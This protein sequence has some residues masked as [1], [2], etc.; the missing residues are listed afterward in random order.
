[1]ITIPRDKLDEP[2]L[3]PE[4][5]ALVRILAAREGEDE[6]VVRYQILAATDAAA[7]GVTTTEKFALAP[8]QI[9]KLSIL[10]KRAG[11]QERGTPAEDAAEFDPEELV[12]LELVV[13][14]VHHKFQGKKG[15]DITVSQ[16]PWGAYWPLGDPKVADF[17]RSV[18]GGRAAAAPAVNGAARQ[19]VPSDDDI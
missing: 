6:V 16:W 10:F 2:V 8:N 7:Q 15:Q 9:G 17:M 4:C 5:R 12:G 3:L 14:V 11:V 19:T 13:D 1:M 18:R